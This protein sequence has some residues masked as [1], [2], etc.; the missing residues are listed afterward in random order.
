M[1]RHCK[2]QFWI[3]YMK[4]LRERLLQMSLHRCLEKD[5]LASRD[6]VGMNMPLTSVFQYVYDVIST[7]QATLPTSQCSP[8]AVVC[9]IFGEDGTSFSC[10]QTNGTDSPAFLFWLP[11]FPLFSHPHHLFSPLQTETPLN[12]TP[13]TNSYHA[14]LVMTIYLWLAFC[15]SQGSRPLS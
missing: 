4:S 13:F 6:G 12:L 8:S 15:P 5:S 1:V 3:Y 7:R 9:S 10:D 2:G 11:F 14:R